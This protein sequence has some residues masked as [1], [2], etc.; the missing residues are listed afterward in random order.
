MDVRDAGAGRPT[1][2]VFV[3]GLFGPLREAGT[4]AQLAPAECSAPDLNG[5]G[6]ASTDQP[7]SV[8]GQVDALRAHVLAHYPGQRV[9][10]VGHSVGAVYAVTLADESP[11]LVASIVSVEGN[12]SL[13]DAFWSKTIAALSA[14]E[15][16]AEIEG[17][18]AD[19]GAF[20]A[21]DGIASTPLLLERAAAALEYQPWR[22]I[23]ETATAIVD[24]TA[25]PAYAA[26]LKRVFERT[27][28]SL[29]AGQRS[30]ARWAVPVW[31]RRAARA[32]AVVP[33]VGHMMM[34]ENP[35]A[36]GRALRLLLD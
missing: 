24:A 32:S 27:P 25:H 11:D 33:G 6:T 21:S 13:A 26:T 18:L 17:R 10:L 23:W 14:E 12:F 22:T 3:H 15:A 28:V 8:R 20:L 35:E 5:Y 16:Q 34:L 31:A 1:P 2:A 4:F 19:A 9:N 36:F 7:V 29:L 30:E